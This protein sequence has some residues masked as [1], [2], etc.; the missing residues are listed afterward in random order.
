[1]YH[2]NRKTM[3]WVGGLELVTIGEHTQGQTNWTTSLM[4]YFKQ[5]SMN[6]YSQIVYIYWC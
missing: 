4:V 5:L 3:F 1:M 6:I 2:D